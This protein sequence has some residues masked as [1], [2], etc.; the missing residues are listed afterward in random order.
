VAGTVPPIPS[1]PGLPR[2]RGLFGEEGRDA[3]RSFL[4]ERGWAAGEI[5]PV[6]AIYRP[7]RSLIV[8]YRAAAEGPV[9]RRS[10]S[11][12]AETRA[13]VR[14]AASVPR[15]FE[16]RYGIADPVD[17]RDGTLLWA[18][19][20]DPSLAGLPDAAWGPWVRGASGAAKPAALSVQPLRYRPRRR[21]VFRYRAL[22]LGR[23][24]RRWETSFGKVLPGDKAERL[25]GTAPALEA[26]R[27][28]VPLALPAAR[29]GPDVLVFPPLAGRSLR[30][31]LVQGGSLPSP[32]RVAGLPAALDAAVTRAGAEI[33]AER[34][35]SIDLAVP[36]ADLIAGLVPSAGD[37]ARR[38]VDAVREGSEDRDVAPSIVHGDLYEAQVFVGRGFNLGLIDLDDLGRGD[39]ALDAAN[40]C[41]H[42]LALALAVPSAADRLVAYRRLVRR[43]FAEALG[44]S[45]RA[46]AWREALCMLLLAA[47][48]FRVLDPSWQDAV[49]RRAALA[50]RLLEDG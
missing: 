10:L 20:Y 45:P 35:A 21:A 11:V 14:P 46:L 1:D 26:A 2:G 27:R 19:P 5:R 39:P 12:C 24:G 3:V 16:K 41:A 31:V 15:G 23:R 9:G 32:A 18:Y 36:G 34:P 7:G 42:L 8:R 17:R 28:A 44:L 38:V 43:A 33:S 30:D 6:Q 37:D 50:V 49:R 25:V 13:R 4:S 47:G 48:P 22:H 40:F 29:A